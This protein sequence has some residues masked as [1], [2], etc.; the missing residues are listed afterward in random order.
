M[1]TRA[2][3]AVPSTK[4]WLRLRT[5]RWHGSRIDWHAYLFVLPFFVP[6]FLF[7]VLA[8][9]FGL[10]VSFTQWGIVG[11][12]KWLGLTNY[13]D[14]LTNPDVPQAWWNT[15]R[16]GLMTVP[17]VIVLALLLAMY[18][19]RRLPGSTFARTTF[20]TPYVLSA[21]V[22]AVVWVWILDTQLGILN[23]YLTMIGIPQIPWITNQAWAL[24]SIAG[25]GIWWDTGFIMVILLAA[26][27]DVPTELREAAA[28]DGANALQIVLFVVL[29]LLRPALSLAL[30]I[31]TINGLRVFSLIFLVTN[32]GPGGATESIVHLIYQSGF[33]QYHLGQAAALA[34]LLFLTILSISAV[35]LRLLRVARS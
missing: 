26:L 35:Q 28:I 2:A 29:P 14:A 1:V 31:Q 6:F 25:I 34:V 4:P 11:S 10:Y 7:Q 15:L 20:F 13:L 19:N 18:V 12:P 33:V 9:A 17:S 8:I 32:G 5:A 30:T 16:Y 3:P 22:V 24:P 23:H 27:Q 21:T